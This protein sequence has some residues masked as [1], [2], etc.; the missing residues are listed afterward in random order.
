MGGANTFDAGDT[1]ASPELNGQI[2]SGNFVY[3]NKGIKWIVD[4]GSDSYY[5]L[6]Y[7]GNYRHNYYRTIGEGHNIVLI[8]DIQT[9]Q[10]TTGSGRLYETYIDKDGKGSY[11]LIDNSNAYGTYSG[12]ALR[13]MLVTND[14]NTVV[15][16]DEISRG[17]AG[18]ITWV[19]NTYKEIVID[20]TGRT[21]YLID[22]TNG[23]ETVLRASIISSDDTLVFNVLTSSDSAIL[24]GTTQNETRPIGDVNRLVVEAKDVLTV[25]IAVAFEIVESTGDPTPVAYDYVQL[26]SWNTVFD[27]SKNTSDTEKFDSKTSEFVDIVTQAMAIYAQYLQ[28]T[29]RI[30]DFHKYISHIRYILFE[31]GTLRGDGTYGPSAGSFDPMN[32]KNYS[33]YYADYETYFDEYTEYRARVVST[34][35]QISRLADKLSGQ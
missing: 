24:K 7:F 22:N 32:D 2:D 26:S 5:A 33:S 28:F 11:A 35:T 9:G 8:P 14:R 12:S 10:S 16:Q 25:N 23:V 19:V 30:A 34:L 18:K 31:N 13:G 6:Y 27:D 3:E 21:A 29:T 20:E 4:H 15:I 17:S 1:E